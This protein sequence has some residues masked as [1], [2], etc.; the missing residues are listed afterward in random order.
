MTGCPAVTVSLVLSKRSR[1]GM[2]PMRMVRRFFCE[3]KA[4]S[5]ALRVDEP[6]LR[7]AKENRPDAITLDVLMP[8]MDGWTVLKS[9]KD[10]P[11]TINLTHMKKRQAA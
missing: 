9:L 5:M 11:D 1:S 2:Q 3:S 8:S 6:A 4:A 10:D 7:L